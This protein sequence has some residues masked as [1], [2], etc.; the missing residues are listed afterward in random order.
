MVLFIICKNGKYYITDII[1]FGHK[2]ITLNDVNEGRRHII[3]MSE[4][5]TIMP[6]SKEA[7]LVG[8]SH[9]TIASIELMTK[10]N[11]ELVEL[12]DSFEPF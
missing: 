5:A 4:I 6:I 2:N 8:D 10:I 1:A 3:S 9:L 12:I 7:S 11:H